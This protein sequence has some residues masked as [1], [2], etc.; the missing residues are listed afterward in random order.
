MQIENDLEGL[1]HI[2]ELS[3]DHVDKVEAVVK[4]GQIVKAEIIKLIP[5]EQKIGLTLKGIDQ[6]DLSTNEVSQNVVSELNI[7]PEIAINTETKEE[8]SV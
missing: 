5:D 2:S 7:A 6:S 3:Y 1:I 4:V 8:V